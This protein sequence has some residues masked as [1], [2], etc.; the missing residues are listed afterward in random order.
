MS[1]ISSGTNIAKNT[2]KISIFINSLIF[3]SKNSR[4]T[5]IQGWIGEMR[6]PMNMEKNITLKV[7]YDITLT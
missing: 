7:K 1:E 2:G 5:E 3:T 4:E 6:Y